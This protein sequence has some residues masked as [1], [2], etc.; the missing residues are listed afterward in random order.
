MVYN[1]NYYECL[2]AANG[3]AMAD[4]V[5]V[6]MGADNIIYK[7]KAMLGRVDTG[8]AFILWK[9]LFLFRNLLLRVPIRTINN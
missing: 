8:I 1:A 7:D 3:D 9:S 4:L 2:H 6:W 5:C